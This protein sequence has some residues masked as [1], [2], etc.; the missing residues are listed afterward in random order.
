MKRPRLSLGSVLIVVFAVAADCVAMR[1][2]HDR[3]MMDQGAF[4]IRLMLTLPMANLLAVVLASLIWGGRTPRAFRVGFIVGGALAAAVTFGGTRPALDW[5]ESILQSTAFGAWLAA[6]PTRGMAFGYVVLPGLALLFQVLA[7]AAL[8][9]LAKAIAPRAETLACDDAPRRWKLAQPLTAMLLIAA[10]A[11]LI[12]GYQRWTIDPTLA[13]LPAGSKAVVDIRVMNGWRVSIGDGST[14]LLSN[15]S[16]V[17]VDEDSQPS[18]VAGVASSRGEQFGD[19]RSVRVTLL[20]GERA[21]Q[22]TSVPR[23]FLRSVR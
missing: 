8:G 16:E 10:P 21:G 11:V 17:E 13:R 20:D 9:R 15:G 6:S 19:H 3:P 12:E 2:V 22:P 7:A 14:F 1:S 23:Q 5:L 18:V 4:E